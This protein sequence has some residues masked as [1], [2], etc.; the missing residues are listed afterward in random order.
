MPKLYEISNELRNI[1]EDGDVWVNT[2]TGEVFDEE[3]LNALQLAFKEKVDGCAV[4]YK[5]LL[6][7]AEI[8]KNE[9]KVLAER[10]KAKANRAE[11]L[12]QYIANNLG[13]NKFESDH[14]KIFFRKS[15]SVVVTDENA[16][17]KEFISEQVVRNVNKL[18]L[19][20]A[21]QQGEVN[22]CY[23]EEKQNVQIK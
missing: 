23:L 7:D 20:K 4:I 16:I 6:A 2:D 5:E 13:G 21:L 17:P 11:W 19:K 1:V 15:V 14:A 10:A 18:E 8:L 22:G 3:K 12:K 9:A